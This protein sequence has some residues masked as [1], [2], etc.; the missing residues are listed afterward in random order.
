MDKNRKLYQSPKKVTSSIPRKAKRVLR[1][2]LVLSIFLVVAIALSLSWINHKKKNSL[3]PYDV[4]NNYIYEFE[5]NN[6]SFKLN[7]EVENNKVKLPEI[8]TDWDT[9][10]LKV[11]VRTNFFGRYFQPRIELSA[12]DI[13]MSQYVEHG[14]KGIRYLNLSH[15]VSSGKREISLIGYNVSIKDQTAELILFKNADISKSRILLI[16]PHPDDAEIAAYGL[17]SSNKDSFIVTIT[18]G[19]AGEKKYDEIYRDDISHYLKKGELKVWNSITVPLLG[20]I[21]IENTINLGYFDNTLIQ[22]YMQKDTFAQSAQIKFSDIN[23]FRKKNVSTLIAN[24]HATVNWKSLVNDLQFLIDKIKPNIIVAPYPAI[25]SHYDHK[26]S[27]IALIEA[28]KKLNLM[29]GD[30]YLY[31][32]HLV[33]SEFYP[34]GKM[35][36]IISLPPNFSEPLYFQKIYSHFLS[37][38]KQND[39]LFALEA[40][41]DL[42]LD[43]EWRYIR[44]AAK[45]LKMNLKKGIFGLDPSYFRRAVRSNELFFIMPIKSVYDDEIYN[46]LRGEFNKTFEYSN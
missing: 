40:M 19:E 42:R 46:R 12:N 32:N 10:F 21:P 2:F 41:N 3:Y 11:N 37:F 26:L 1:L 13:T 35:G 45:L 9:A 17:Y 22:M 18:A 6:N 44:G 28:I 29:E 43:T 5:I 14:G 38:D 39:K 36:S 27:T 34:H 4:T 8:A 20:G 15:F 7:L 30:L 16:A 25:D 23:V 31:T 33:L 24:L